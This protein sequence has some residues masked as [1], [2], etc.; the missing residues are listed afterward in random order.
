MREVDI[1]TENPELFIKFH[2]GSSGENYH[3]YDT[4]EKPLLNIIQLHDIMIGREKVRLGRIGKS[5]PDMSGK[6]SVE[7]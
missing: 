4:E 6:V 3:V 5:H 1:F 2:A 7:R